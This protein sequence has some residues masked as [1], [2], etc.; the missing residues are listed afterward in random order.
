MGQVQQEF[1]A[2]LEQVG[3]PFKA[4]E[5]FGSQIIVT[6][7][8]RDTADK[9]ASLLSR[10]SKVKGIVETFD[11]AKVNK[12]TALLPSRVKVWRTYATI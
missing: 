6:A 10:F 2:K 11:Y 1:K 4:V 9:W 3:L 12:N 5:C 7:Q 8:S